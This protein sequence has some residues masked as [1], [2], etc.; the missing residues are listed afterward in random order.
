MTA[1][2]LTQA[3]I[4]EF[5]SNGAILLKG[6]FDAKWV[7]VA[8]AG[9]RRTMEDPSEKSE[10]LRPVANEGG[11]FNDYCN[12]RKFPELVDYV[13]NSPAASIVGQLMKCKFR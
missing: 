9:I 1:V 10:M 6:V 4:E 12:W 13:Y 3:Q 11:Y 7:D 8:Q 2:T 5:E